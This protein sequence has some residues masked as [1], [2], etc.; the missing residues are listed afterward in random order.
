MRYFVLILAAFLLLSSC[1]MP[2]RP[3]EYGRYPVELIVVDRVSKNFVARVT[4]RSTIIIEREY[5]RN[6]T[7]VAHELCHIVQW[8]TL[9]A[10]FPTLYA[11]LWI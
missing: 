10:T 4:S 8:N 3:N 1:G 7:I 2:T 11:K 6:V 9:G 5:K